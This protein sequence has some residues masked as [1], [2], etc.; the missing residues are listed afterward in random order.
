MEGMIRVLKIELG[1]ASY[2]KAIANDY[3]ASQREVEG[4]IAV[5]GFG[6]GHNSAE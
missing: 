2:V 1:K 3:R 5:F 6:D 4:L